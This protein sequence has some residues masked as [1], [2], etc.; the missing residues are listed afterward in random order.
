MQIRN[1]GLNISS[2]NRNFEKKGSFYP[3]SQEISFGQRLKADTVELSLKCG[4]VG[5]RN[6]K[7][8]IK[9]RKAAVK[10]AQ[11]NGLVTIILNRFKEFSSEEY[12][13]LT[14]K[15]KKFLRARYAE[16][17]K[18]DPTNFRQR[19]EQMHDVA[20]DEIKTCL[21]SEFGSG[22]YKVITIGQSLSSI[23][24]VLGYKIGEENVI[25]LPMSQTSKYQFMVTIQELEQD[26]SISRY[27]E[28]LKKLGL[29]KNKIE[30]SDKQYILMDYCLS[31]KSLR[32]ATKLLTQPSLLGEKNIHSRNVLRC[33]NHDTRYQLE[34]DLRRCKYKIYSFV[35]KAYQLDDSAKAHRDLSKVNNI[36]R[37]MWFKLLDN[38]MLK[39]TPPKQQI[40][41][42][43]KESSIIG[44][45]VGY[46]KSLF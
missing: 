46:I 44:S 5:V 11:N 25:N 42:N 36:T 21:D 40:V 27:R 23:G 9:Q 26:G 30:K 34:S 15:E 12:Q 4:R 37:L 29:E 35:N 17:V 43:T 22:K 45:V 32:G 31:G 3:C 24:K 1:Y 19:A 18:Q 33:V 14:E 2:E 10:T 39:K 6:L 41:E 8:I 38:Q 20:S 7:A 28:Y 13:R 16:T